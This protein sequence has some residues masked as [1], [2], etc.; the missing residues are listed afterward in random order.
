MKG[1][2]GTSSE[3]IFNQSPP[4]GEVSDFVEA[5]AGLLTSCFR[6]KTSK[7]MPLPGTSVSLVSFFFKR[8]TR[9]KYNCRFAIEF[10]C[11]FL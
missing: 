1:M 4:F 3:D 11:L 5:L 10:L 9:K 7:R 6:Q 8:P 2:S